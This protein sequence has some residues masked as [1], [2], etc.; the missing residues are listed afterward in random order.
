MNDFRDE[1]ASRE[2][3]EWA[4]RAALREPV[5]MPARFREQVLARALAAETHGRRTW[6]HR[7]IAAGLLAAALLG[8]G[9]DAL[10][11]RTTE[12]ARARAQFAHCRPDARNR[13]DARAG[14]A[15]RK[16]GR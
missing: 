3:V 9:G 12:R 11:R 6:Q 13:R 1:D 8:I 16:G 15:T 5:A 10:H 14:R 7:A 4:L 2:E